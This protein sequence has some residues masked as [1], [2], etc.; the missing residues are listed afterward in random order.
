MQQYY[1]LRIPWIVHSLLALYSS[2][3]FVDELESCV[4]QSTPLEL[5]QQHVVERR[6]GLKICEREIMHLFASTSP[7]PRVVSLVQSTS[8]AVLYGY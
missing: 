7:P 8:I 5:Q 1:F 4:L 6:C 3:L 2:C